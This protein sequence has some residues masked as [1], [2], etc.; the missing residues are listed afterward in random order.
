LKFGFGLVL[1]GCYV[2]FL[3]SNFSHLILGGPHP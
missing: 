1:L 3:I 2:V